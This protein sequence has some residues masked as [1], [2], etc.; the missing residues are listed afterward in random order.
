MNEEGFFGQDEPEASP[1]YWNVPL[2][3]WSVC[4]SA[5]LLPSFMV[6]LVRGLAYANHCVPGP[7]LCQGWLRFGGGLRDTLGLAWALSTNELA[8]VGMA[9]IASLAALF[10]RKP[11]LAAA[12][13]LLF[14]IAALVLPLIAVLTSTYPGCGINEAGIGSCMLWGADQ[15]MSFHQSAS[16]QGAI[17]SFAPYT[18]ALSLMIG[19]LGW[20]FAR[21]HHA[22]P[23]RTEAHAMRHHFERD[24]R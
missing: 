20:F 1:K 18:F 16:V 14:P 9:F 7:A 13:L 17:Y 6:W 21:P 11:L 12:S 23:P 19:I 15:G 3:I 5:L 2:L 22:I 24:D 8:L 10:S 4:A